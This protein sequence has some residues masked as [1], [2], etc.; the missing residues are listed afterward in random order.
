MK[1]ITM[2][3][4]TWSFGLCLCTALLTMVGTGCSGDSEPKETQSVSQAPPVHTNRLAGQ[5]SPYLLQH[6]HNPVNWYPWGDEAFEAAARQNKPVFLSIGYSSCHWCHV[7]EHESFSKDDVAA[8]LNEHFIS[9]KVDRE[10]RPDVDDIYMTAVQLMTRSGGW[11]LSVFLTPDREP[12]FGGTYFP[13]DDRY[14]RPGFKSLL[15]NIATAW[16]TRREDIHADAARLTGAVRLAM[17]SES[18]RG[19]TPAPALLDEA[20]ATLAGSYDEQWGGFGGAP[21]FPPA[22]ALAFLL[23]RHSH[24][25]D[26]APLAIVEHTLQAMARG[27]MYDQLGGG[28]HRYA[29]DARWLVPHF[30]K[31]LYDNALLSRVYTEAWQVTGDPFYRRIATETLDYVLRD[32]TGPGGGF[33]SA[34]DADSEGVEGKFYVWSRDEL[35]ALLGDETGALI[36]DFFG[37]SGKGNFEGHNILHEPVPRAEFA[38]KRGLTAEA[39]AATISDARAVLLRERARRIPP[40]TDDKVITAWNGMMI[41]SMARAGAAF[42]DP[43]Y[44]EAAERAAAFITRALT[45]DDRLHRS[46]RGDVIGPD[47]FLDDYAHMAMAHIDLYEATFDASHLTRSEALLQILQQ[48]FRSGEAPGFVFA[49]TN[50]TDLLAASRPM[51]DGAIPSGNAI[52]MTAMFRLYRLTGNDSLRERADAMLHAMTPSAGS[53]PHSSAYA[54]I[55][56]E[57]MLSSPRELVLAGAKEHPTTQAF[58]RTIRS[59]FLPNAV[60]AWGPGTSEDSAAELIPLLRDRASVEGQPALYV[61]EGFACRQ[62]ITDPDQF[63]DGRREQD[64]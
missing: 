33:Y 6:A 53:H 30:E 58:L 10:E 31:M 18:T 2:A 12:F 5:S 54:L 36:A 55:A 48:D 3:F 26:P 1:I 62:P 16:A 42:D 25:D 52:A 11:P 38:A 22:G 61:C 28:F 63:S 7:M 40:L 20:A 19:M 34:Q 45:H 46:W 50:R 14:G 13:P 43:R 32:M 37:V 21:K 23:R 41:G 17:Q 8:I 4:T 9:I 15:D 35:L 29:V 39:L 27:G 57:F 24:T 47:G 64:R 49:P 51:T 56:M 44:I 59:R 60:I